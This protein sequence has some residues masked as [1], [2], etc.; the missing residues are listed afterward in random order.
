MPKL[1]AAFAGSTRNIKYC[2]A[3][4]Q[5]GQAAQ[6]FGLRIVTIKPSGGI[7][8]MRI[9]GRCDR[10]LSARVGQPSLGG[11]RPCVGTTSSKSAEQSVG[12]SCVGRN[13][14]M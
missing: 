8:G 1:I 3:H 10:V 7:S 4:S 6:R 5:A 2:I 11:Q 14:N 13:N 12:Q 9:G